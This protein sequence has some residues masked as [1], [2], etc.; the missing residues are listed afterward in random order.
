MNNS[1][2]RV[3]TLFLPQALFLLFVFSLGVAV[4]LFFTLLFRKMEVGAIVDF[5][6]P[7][8]SVEDLGGVS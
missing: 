2:I 6:K 4:K 8:V 1:K 7:F 3:Y 5:S